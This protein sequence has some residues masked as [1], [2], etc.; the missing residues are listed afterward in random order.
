MTIETKPK[1]GGARPGAGRPKGSG[2][3]PTQRVEDDFTMLELLE[4][5]A[6]GRLEISALQLKAATVAVAYTA[7]KLADGGK[8]E[9]R[10]A[11]AERELDALPMTPPPLRAVG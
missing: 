6:L 5:V 2:T 3:V 9:M 11:E 7:T 1:R 10:Q 8:R 4:Q